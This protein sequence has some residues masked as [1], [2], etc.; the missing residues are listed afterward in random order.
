MHILS[1]RQTERQKQTERQRERLWGIGSRDDGYQEITKSIVFELET[2]ESWWCSSSPS[3]KAWEPVSQWCGSSPKAVRKEGFSLTWRQ[4]GEKP[5]VLFR[6]STNWLMLTHLRR[7]IRC[8]Q[9]TDLNP[10]L[11]QKHPCRNT[12]NNI[13]SNLRAPHGW[14]KLTHK[15]NI[16]ERDGVTL[17]FLTRAVRLRKECKA[18]LLL[19]WS[20]S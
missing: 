11:I 4:W 16:R 6:P 13:W 1:P 9:S 2:Q 17:R 8:T 20:A 18:S 7:A 19:I 15:I 14:V 10:N 5:L 12:R 3:P